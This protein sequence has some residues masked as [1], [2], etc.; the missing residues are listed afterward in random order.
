MRRPP[1]HPYMQAIKHHDEI[2]VL[3]WVF[4]SACNLKTHPI[5]KTIPL[6]GSC[7]RF[8]RAGVIIKAHE[9]R[10]RES[11]CHEKS[12]G[13]VA[14]ADIGNHTTAFEFGGDAVKCRNPRAYQIRN[15]ARTEEFLGSAKYSLVMLVP[16]LPAPLRNPSIARGTDFREPRTSSNAL[17]R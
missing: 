12:R 3:T 1:G 11:F 10:V 9:A 17:G 15:I 6:G 16:P 13:A 8:H 4:L 14:A 7:C 5:G 2:I